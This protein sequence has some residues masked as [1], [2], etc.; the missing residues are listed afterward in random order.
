MLGGGCIIDGVISGG[1][2]GIDAGI[3]GITHARNIP[4]PAHQLLYR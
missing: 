2:G 3:A 4:S 1:I